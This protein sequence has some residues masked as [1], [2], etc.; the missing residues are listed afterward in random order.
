[1]QITNN[2]RTTTYRKMLNLCDSKYVG[3]GCK[4]VNAYTYYLLQKGIE[5]VEKCEPSVS[6]STYRECNTNI[7][8]DNDSVRAKL[9]D[10]IARGLMLKSIAVNAGLSESELSRLKNGVDSLKDSDVRLLAEYLNAVV[11]PQWN[12]VMPEK[13]LMTARER[14]L[15]SKNK[16][17]GLSAL[18]ELKAKRISK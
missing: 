8:Y 16:P 9:A 15:A 10:I 7:S 6:N 3:K 18:E 2:S 1:M 17:K 11:I 13:K 12:T 4:A 14:L 5:I